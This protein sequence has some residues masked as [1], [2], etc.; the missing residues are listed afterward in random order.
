M[1]KSLQFFLVLLMIASTITTT[2]QENYF[3]KIE[4]NKIDQQGLIKKIKPQKYL[5]INA[6]INKLKE[7]C[8]ALP[9]ENE[10]MTNRNASPILS[11]PMPNGSFAKFHVWES[12]IQEKGLSEKFPEIKT[13][14][15]Q[16][17]DDPYATI[18]F[19]ITD[20]GFHA[21]I[22]SINGNVYID[23]Y[24]RGTIK[25]YISYYSRDNIH[26]SNFVCHVDNSTADIT[27]RPNATGPC[28]GTS[29]YTYRIA[30][31]CTGEY[32]VAVGGTTASLLHSAIVTSV[33]RVD[34]VYESEVAVRLILVA[35]N[36]LIEFLNAA[37]DPFTGNNNG[38]TLINESQ[39]QIT[40][41]IG[42]ANFDIGHTFSTGGGG[43]A[44]LGVVCSNGSKASGITGS[45]NPVGDAYDIDYVAHEIGHQFSGNHSFNST[46]SNCGGGNRNAGTA[47]EVG[48]GTT[49]MAYAGICS[50][51]DIQLHS[52]PFFHAISFDE[53]SNYLESGG[54][55]KVAIATGNTLPQITVMNNS[56]SFIPLKTPFTLSGSA[57]DANSDAIT[58]CW[59]EWDLGTAGAWNNGASSAT[60][61]LF[62]SRIPKTTGS[63]T[64][65]DMSYILANYLPATPTATMAGQKG[66]TLPTVARTMKFRLTVRDNRSGGGGVVSGGNGCQSGFTGVFQ[67]TAVTGTGPFAVT[68]PNGGESWAGNATQTVTWNV[69][70]T[71]IAPISTA[72][73]R[74]T[75]STD[76]GLTYPTELIAS[77][78]NDGSEIITTPNI[79]TSTARIR[80]EAVGN[81]Y[82]DISNANFSIVPSS[83][84]TFNFSNSTGANSL[85]G[86]NNSIAAN[87]TSTA[88]GGFST[89]INLTAN[90]N[91][92]GTTVSFGSSN[93]TPGSTTTVILNNA[94][95]LAVGTYNV[96]VTGTAG[97]TT[98][99][100][101]IPFI[102]KPGNAPSII[103]QPIDFILHSGEVASFSVTS[104]SPN[105]TYQWQ[106][107][108]NDGVDFSNITGE[109]ASTLKINNA[110]LSSNNYQY[111]VKIS[112]QCGDTLSSAAKLLIEGLFIY[113]NPNKGLFSVLYNDNNNSVTSRT[114]IIYDAKGSKVYA[115]NYT[116]SN[117]HFD[118]MN[119][120]MRKMGNGV[121]FI[122][123]LDN[124]GKRLTSSK[125]LIY[126]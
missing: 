36:N 79:T 24:A 76:G 46:S 41:R 89:P 27:Q 39:T 92:S 72:N 93:L 55:C 34:G 74:I 75:L 56:A 40:N 20:F 91:P 119:V 61:P 99:T 17:I 113:P 49:I 104:P 117:N 100:T 67:V 64:F 38:G 70:G 29:L 102:I 90:G 51:D 57:T 58:Y 31:A 86:A 54:T 107:S 10:V 126:K 81:I 116:M 109:N 112:N 125:F 118:A 25:E 32:A 110:S 9:S 85:C 88:I 80:I 44:S 5:V 114:L 45:P 52:D 68:A 35:N 26:E 28:R 50:T 47:Y 82:F 6:D 73:V 30:V 13:F 78:P 59:E 16:G 11:L 94:A 108:S 62:K 124:T 63:R 65:P 2:A 115:E 101:I 122:N 98:K 96:T 1:K 123:L 23:P 7:F 111:R 21:Q 12:S 60:A 14:A 4:E 42:S 48:S 66:E 84:I 106:K 71:S 43:L 69:A 3:T 121:Y 18:R 37:T 87:L 33:N 97:T 53:I 95:N 105:L 83:N 120:D 77:T 22:I 19:D 103:T 15:G 8:W